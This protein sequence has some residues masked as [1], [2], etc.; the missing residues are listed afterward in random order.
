MSG[1]DAPLK[2]AYELA[3]ERLQA[4]DREAGADER[5]ALTR[6]QKETIADLRQ[7]AKARLAEIEIL[8]RKE[9]AGATDPEQLTK[10]EERYEID[11]RRVNS[12]LETSVA[13]VRRGEQPA[14]HD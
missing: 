7:K 2:S 3:M 13:R 6:E 4:K 8:H 5:K 1:H 12:R 11:R 14:D 9:L 10:L